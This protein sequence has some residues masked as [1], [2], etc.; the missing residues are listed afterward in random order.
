MG[1]FL[2]FFGFAFLLA[3]GCSAV[4][5]GL[6]TGGIIRISSIAERSYIPVGPK[7]STGFIPLFC[8]CL[9]TVSGSR[10]S[11]SAMYEIGIKSF[12]IGFHY[13]LFFR[14]S[15][16]LFRFWDNLLYRYLVISEKMLNN[17]SECGI[18]TLKN[19]SECGII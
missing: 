11:S 7:Y 19:Y 9:F 15:Q 12:S 5:L 14:K 18:F 16:Q 1:Y 13:R 6:P 2:A 3:G 17:Y 10:F 8:S 4:F